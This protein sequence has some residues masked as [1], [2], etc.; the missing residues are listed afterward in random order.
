M[1]FSAMLTDAFHGSD[2]RIDIRYWTDAKIFN[3]RRLQMKTKLQEVNGQALQAVDKF[4]YLSTT[5]SC[6]VHIDDETN[7]RIAKASVAFNRLY[8]SV[9]ECK[10]INQQ[11]KPK[12]YKASVANPDVWM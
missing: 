8:A 7:A 5:L 6:A 9:W 1:M 10:G 2:T 11:T 4:T 12:V 3:L